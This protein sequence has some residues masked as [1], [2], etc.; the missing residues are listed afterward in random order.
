MAG[1]WIS[2]KEMYFQASKAQNL[3]EEIERQKNILAI[4]SK[5]VSVAGMCVICG[6][7]PN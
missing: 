2:L 1:M 6:R 4:Y 5:S 7:N 3:V